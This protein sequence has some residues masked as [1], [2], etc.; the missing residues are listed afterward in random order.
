M[1]TL[2]GVAPMITLLMT[3]FLRPLASPSFFQG[4]L[5]LKVRVRVWDLG[6]H[7]LRFRLRV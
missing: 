1:G 2:N 4:S 5:F 3:D 7:L 6:F